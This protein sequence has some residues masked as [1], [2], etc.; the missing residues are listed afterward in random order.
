MPRTTAPA[1][2]RITV[3]GQ[4]VEIR[5]SARRKRSVQA[6]FEDGVVVVLAPATL[7]AREETRIVEDLV[8][9]MLRKSRSQRNDDTLMRRAVALSRRF[10]PGAP[11]PASVRWVS[12]MTTRWASCSPGDASIRLSDTMVGMPDYV[13]DAVL[14]HEVTH[15]L[16]RG[17]GPRFQ[18]IV[19]RYP[20]HERAQAFLAGASF[21]ARRAA[22]APSA[23]LDD[24]LGEE[25]G[26]VAD[27]TREP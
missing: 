22:P 11:E 26:D 20:E 10:V 5:R 3:D 8:R 17:H 12:N 15:L 24:D 6:R 4:D 18:E 7:S 13:V 16:E 19:C 2:T 27:P 21:G 1:P 14:L 25:E 23:S 9:K